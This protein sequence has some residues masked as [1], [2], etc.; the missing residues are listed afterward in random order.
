[1]A[2]S[3]ER[4]NIGPHLDPTSTF[5]INF[6]PP[7]LQKQQPHGFYTVPSSYEEIINLAGGI[8][9]RALKIKSRLAKLTGY[10]L[11][12]LA[13]INLEDAIYNIPLG[14]GRYL[15]ILP[16]AINQSTNGNRFAVSFW[17]ANKKLT[18]DTQKVK[19][20]ISLTEE[21]LAAIDTE[22]YA[23]CRKM[24]L[25]TKGG[26]HNHRSIWARDNCDL[27]GPLHMAFFWKRHDN[28]TD[29]LLCSKKGSFADERQA[30][31]T[32]ESNLKKRSFASVFDVEDDSEAVEEEEVEEEEKCDEEVAFHVTGMEAFTAGYNMTSPPKKHARFSTAQPMTAPVSHATRDPRGKAYPR[33]CTL[34]LAPHQP[35]SNAQMLARE[36][37]LRTRAATP[38]PQ[39]RRPLAN[40]QLV[41]N[42]GED[43][44]VFGDDDD[45]AFLANTQSVLD[46]PKSPELTDGHAL[47]PFEKEDT[48]LINGVWRERPQNETEEE[49]DEEEVGDRRSRLST[50]IIPLD[51]VKIE[52]QSGSN[53][54]PLENDGGIVTASDVENFV[55]DIRNQFP[56]RN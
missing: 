48:V 26:G 16:F 11:S 29:P 12:A 36:P 5:R 49:E 40:L 28:I 7:S 52:A 42:N 38:S 25:L 14:S 32:S 31:G 8:A 46:A 39:V 35:R 22:K 33:P 27:C 56:P 23:I 10:S 55:K 18:C 45:V 51:P 13:D 44:D 2:F 15:V 34:A 47:F 41:S 6:S 54:G 37:V 24:H 43:D 4:R 21:D 17:I 9:A 50:P 20:K 19:G 1:M 3:T 53:L 30:A